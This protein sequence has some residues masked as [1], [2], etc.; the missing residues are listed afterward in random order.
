MGFA[1]GSGTQNGLGGAGAV[2]NQAEGSGRS[3]KLTSVVLLGAV[4]PGPLWVRVE[5]V[6]DQR[7]Q[8]WHQLNVFPWTAML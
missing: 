6:V 1:W 8:S 3:P 7:P 4:P 5:C 2:V